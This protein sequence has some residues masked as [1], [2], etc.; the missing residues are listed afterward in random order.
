MAKPTKPRWADANPS[1]AV[2]PSEGKKDTGWLSGEKPPFQYM[3]W[4]F[5]KVKA[6]IDW[7]ENKIQ[8][9]SENVTMRSDNPVYWD[10]A[11]LTFGSAI[12]LVP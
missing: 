2:E 1:F 6:W 5:L 7:F 10:G 8:S 9:S 11:A 3:N 4:L 12:E